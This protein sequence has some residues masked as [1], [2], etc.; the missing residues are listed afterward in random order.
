MVGMPEVSIGTTRTT[1]PTP[2]SGHPRTFALRSPGAK[3]WAYGFCYSPTF[4]GRTLADW[5]GRELREY[6]VKDPRRL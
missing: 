3:S 2:S 4:N 6:A 1:G 5:Y